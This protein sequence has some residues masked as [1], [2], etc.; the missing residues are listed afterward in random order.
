MS[1]R[2]H[3]GMEA[4]DPGRKEFAVMGPGTWVRVGGDQGPKSALRWNNQETWRPWR[5]EVENGIFEF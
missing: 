4:G 3:A 5:S 1:W 2:D